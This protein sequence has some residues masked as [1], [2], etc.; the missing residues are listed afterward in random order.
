MQESTS[1]SPVIGD[2]PRRGRREE[3]RGDGTIFEAVNFFSLEIPCRCP[4]QGA[5]Y[6][7]ASVFLR[8]C[9]SYRSPLDGAMEARVL[10]AV[11]GNPRKDDNLETIFTV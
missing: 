2:L 7:V 5:L 4:G 8:R 11:L 6:Q 9:W 1:S 10:I 3:R